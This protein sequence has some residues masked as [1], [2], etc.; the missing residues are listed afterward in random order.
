[1][2][3]LTW[4]DLVEQGVAQ[5]TDDV[6]SKLEA[7]LALLT[8]YRK[9][10]IPQT[11]SISK[12]DLVRHT[13]DGAPYEVLEVFQNPYAN[14]PTEKLES[15]TFAAYQMRDDAFWCKLINLDNNIIYLP[16]D[17]LVKIGE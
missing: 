11:T 1:M 16:A 13:L 2:K 7:V 17:R 8:I 14:V 12:G 4:N 6:N 9:M 5:P 3:L 10:G 15:T